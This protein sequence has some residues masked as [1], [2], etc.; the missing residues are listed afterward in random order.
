MPHLY[1]KSRWTKDAKAYAELAAI[2]N[3]L[4]WIV[5]IVG[6]VAAIIDLVVGFIHF[7][8]GGWAAIFG[9]FVTAFLS[10]MIIIFG[11]MMNGLS[12][13]LCATFEMSIGETRDYLDRE[14][15]GAQDE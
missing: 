4:C 12:R 2:F 15:V 14:T 9:A 3:V 8:D 6:T 7:E 5:G 13:V 1:E 10:F 11:M